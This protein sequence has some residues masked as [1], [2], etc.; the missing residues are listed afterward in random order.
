MGSCLLADLFAQG[1]DLSLVLLTHGLDEGLL[2]FDGFGQDGDEGDIVDA[3]EL[4]AGGMGWGFQAF[5]GL[6]AGEKGF[7]LGEA[8]ARVLGSD[9]EVRQYLLDVLGEETVLVAFWEVHAEV[10]FVL[11][12]LGLQAVEDVQCAV[13]VLNILLGALVRNDSQVAY[14]LNI[15]VEVAC[16]VG[17]ACCG[18][19][20]AVADAGGGTVHLNELAITV[21]RACARHIGMSGHAISRGPRGQVVVVSASYTCCGSWLAE[22]IVDAISS[23]IGAYGEAIMAIYRAVGHCRRAIGIVQEPIA[24]CSTC[25]GDIVKKAIFEAGR[26]CIVGELSGVAVDR[27]GLVDVQLCSRGGCPDAYVA[28][29]VDGQ[30]GLEGACAECCEGCHCSNGKEFLEFHSDEGFRGYMNKLIDKMVVVRWVRAFRWGDG[31]Q[32]QRSALN[33]GYR[34]TL[35]TRLYRMG[36]LLPFRSG[37]GG[38]CSFSSLIGKHVSFSSQGLLGI[39]LGLLDIVHASVAASLWRLS[40]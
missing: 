16:K 19:I 33:H 13:K 9:H 39:H 40:H 24:A 7:V 3:F 14:D 28:I 31:G 23:A 27:I 18:G 11:V 17:C 30:L 21:A 35:L 5:C 10:L 1:L 34:A 26:G 15:A 37:F 25:G 22:V 2:L 29:D 8:N 38:S 20:H 6:L 12:G 4:G 36:I 32:G